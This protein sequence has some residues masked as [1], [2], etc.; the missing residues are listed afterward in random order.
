MRQAIA[1][2]LD[3][4]CDAPLSRS[5]G[6]T[7]LSDYAD[8]TG[9]TR[10]TVVDGMIATDQLDG[11]R[12]RAWVNGEDPA[13]GQRRGRDLRSPNADLVLDGTINT[14]KSFS[15]AA[16]LHPELAGEFEALQDRLRN[17]IVRAW[18]RDLNARRGAGGRVRES[19]ARVEVVELRH[20]R[21]RALDPHIHRHLWLNVKVQGQDGRWSNIDSR[22]AMKFH[23]VVNAEGELAARTDPEWRAALARYGYDL[24]ADGEIVQ[25][26]HLV[27]PL[28]RRSAQ[29]DAN[30]SFKISEWR[31]AHPGQ[32]P[33]PKVLASIDRWAWA[34]GRPNKPA[35][36]T[37]AEWEELVRAEIR[38][39][40]DPVAGPG[41]RPEV[42]WT[43]IGDLDR[44]LL[45]ARALAEADARAVSTGGRFSVFDVRA[46]AMR[47]VAAS[48]VIAERSVLDE[49][50]E[51]VSA[52]ALGDTVFLLGADEDVP[53]HIKQFLSNRTAAVKRDLGARFDALAGSGAPAPDHVVDAVTREVSKGHAL[54]DGQRAAAAAIAGSYR[55]VTVTGPAGSG[56]TTLL[57]V[58]KAVLHRQRR[59]LVIVAP[60]KKAAS[61]A[62]REVGT[63]ASSLHALLF[64]HG[65][66][67]RPDETGAVRWY[68]LRIG[69]TDITGARYGGP[70]RFALNADD[71]IVV[72]EAGMVD[73]DAALALA[74]VAEQ[75]GAGIAMVGDPMQA[76]PVG[77]AGAMASAQR[78]S[79]A[80][81]EMSAIHRFDDADYADLTTRLRNPRSLDQ[82]RQVAAE[83][84]DRG[85]VR[86]VES[87]QEAQELIVE[88][89]FDHADRRERLAIVVATN[90]EAQAINEAIQQE[91]VVR[92]QLTEKRVAWGRDGQRLLV[93][94]VVQTR[95]NDRD[96][97]VENRAV[98]TIQKIHRHAVRLASV[99]DSTDVKDVPHDYIAEHV[100]LSYA[101]TVHG[102]QG[103]TTH[104]SIVGTDVDAAGLYVG[105][106][107][108]RAHNEVVTVASSDRIARERLAESMMR[109]AVEVTVDDSVRAAWSELGR[110]ARAPQGG[111]PEAPRRWDDPR[112]PL[113]S[114]RDLDRHAAPAVRRVPAVRDQIERLGDLVAGDQRTLVDLNMRIARTDAVMHR[115]GEHAE[116]RR[117]LDDLRSVRERLARR[118]VTRE[119]AQQDLR[120]EYRQLTALLDAVAE[121]VQIRAAQPTAIREREDL[122]RAARESAASPAQLID[123]RRARGVVR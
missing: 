90:S 98:W 115:P 45:A 55:L 107:R 11:R 50:I 81:V 66:R 2:A 23:T 65:W 53:A 106:T 34:Q 100:H 79:G 59:R 57:R 77:H 6:V 49:L 78:R 99:T 105:M 18:Q 54:D 69:D 24:T 28:S 103:E 72:D 96:T 95:R 84:A 63:D 1:Y 112:R 21:S 14:P 16:L 43:A 60:T 7:A 122:A 41:R 93:G 97:G 101:S 62:G 91:R 118:L 102:I 3:G 32:E 35:A 64:D 68:Q 121:E 108:G 31:E 73:L 20:R 26:Q 15:V 51:D 123:D 86:R 13:T 30:R 25:L 61:V 114:V 12:L 110:A 119:Q 58:V 104:A 44:D 88:R 87:T 48:G 111:V 5:R 75:T 76:R 117:R 120:K 67:F 80:V 71:R 4:T 17:R 37:E 46:G 74:I 113:G 10:F 52:R 36:F 22:V 42:P 29:I 89:Y 116:P 9:V 40:H 94:D 33:G 8:S 56:K 70:R 39:L 83:L 19:L 27:R 85:H 109:G 92:G 82:A 38:D 47:A